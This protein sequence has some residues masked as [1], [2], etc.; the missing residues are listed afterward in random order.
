MARNFYS[1]YIEHCMRFYARYSHVN[2][3]RSDADRKNWFACEDALK[4][5]SETDRERLICIYREGDTI[6]DNVY[7]LAKK[8]NINQDSVW[9]LIGDLERKVAQKRGLIQ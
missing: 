4:E 2:C 8:E 1:A 5:F 7:Q 3:F 6:S 9:K